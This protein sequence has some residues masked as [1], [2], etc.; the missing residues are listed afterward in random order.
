MNAS[1]VSDDVEPQSA[2]GVGDSVAHRDQTGSR[3]LG[4]TAEE[5]RRRSID[6]RAD[7]NDLE[8]NG[9][10]GLSVRVER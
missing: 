3:N 10:T 2:E 7:D 8:K 1:D 4:V 9:R 5:V 6:S